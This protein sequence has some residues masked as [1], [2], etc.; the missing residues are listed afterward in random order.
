MSYKKEYGTILRQGSVVHITQ[1][2]PVVRGASFGPSSDIGIGLRRVA[3][4]KYDF[5]VDGG[6][7]GEIIPAKTVYLPANAIVIGGIVNV[8]TALLAAGGA[9]T[10]AIGTHAGATTS[11]LMAAT[12]KTSFTL[13][14]LM[15]IVPV[16]TAASAF[17]MSVEG[18]ISITVATNALTAGVMEGF[19]E[20]FMPTA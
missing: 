9:A 16:W 10:I 8:T 13:A 17:K 2:T 7:V 19:V 4:W 5:A 3:H 18:Q 12:N 11:A 20:Y 14:A 1:N 6:V 15:A